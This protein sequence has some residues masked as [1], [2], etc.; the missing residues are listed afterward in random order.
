DRLAPED[1]RLL[2]AASVV[3][4]DVPHPLLQAIAELSAEAL[5]QG[6]ARLHAAEFLYETSFF[7]D[8][9]YTFKHA[10]THEVAYGSLLQER[11]CTLHA[12]I[13]E[14]VKALYPDRQSEQ[15]EWL[16]YHAFRGERWTEAVAYLRQ[17]GEKTL[18]RSAC[19][20][21]AGYLEQALVALDHLP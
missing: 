1:K 17:A 21:A 19:R 18:A 10:L 11:R 9:E 14:A 12:R 13:V 2:Q 5:R 15:V 6:L 4:K 20:E 3:G 8:Q 7:P 16:A